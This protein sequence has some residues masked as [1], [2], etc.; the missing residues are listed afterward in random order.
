MNMKVII[1]FLKIKGKWYLYLKVW[2]SNDIVKII[3]LTKWEKVRQFSVMEALREDLL[4]A[5]MGSIKVRYL[6]DK[7]VLLTGQDGVLM[8]KVVWT[9]DCFKQIADNVGCLIEVDQETS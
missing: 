4:R 2:K 1:E 9:V 3:T 8:N 6:G 5:G 7:D